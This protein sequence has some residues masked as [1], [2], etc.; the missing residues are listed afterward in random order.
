[1]PELKGQKR[2]SGYLIFFQQEQAKE[3]YSCT[4]PI[5]SGWIKSKHFSAQIICLTSI[6]FL[7]FGQRP[8]WKI[9]CQMDHLG[10]L[11]EI[12]MLLFTLDFTSLSST[13][14]YLLTWQHSVFPKWSVLF[15]KRHT[16][17]QHNREGW[18]YL[19]W[20]YLSYL[21]TVP[22]AF[23]LSDIEKK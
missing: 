10:Y 2:L 18:W 5:T 15:L 16:N 11:E 4:K 23:G 19:R 8:W 20:W 21:R 1:M 14:L 3:F 12:S 22:P 17:W 7:C 9:R 13:L 6:W